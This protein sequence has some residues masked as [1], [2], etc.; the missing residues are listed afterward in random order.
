MRRRVT[1]TLKSN[2]KLTAPLKMPARTFGMHNTVAIR[3]TANFGGK[4]NKSAANALHA[5]QA[6]KARMGSRSIAPLILSLGTRW[7]E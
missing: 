5:L 3:Y 6:K 1:A 7:G 4:S 2:I